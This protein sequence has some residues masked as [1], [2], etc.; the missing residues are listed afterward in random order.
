MRILQVIEFFTP[1]MG[2]SPQVVFQIATH[3]AQLGHKVTVCS[4]DY[5]I[6]EAV[7]PSLGFEQLLFPCRFAR[8][9][10]YLTPDLI[11]W[12]WQNVRHFDVIHLH[13]VRTFQNA[14]I[15]AIAQHFGIPYVLSPHGSLPLIAG[16]R[17]AKQAYDLLFGNNLL[18][19]AARLIAVSPAEAEQFKQAGLSDEKIITV[20]NGLNLSEFTQLP[21][22]GLLR[23]ELGISETVALIL[24]LGRLHP[25]KGVD[26]LIPAFAHLLTMYP[27]AYLVVAGPDDGDLVRLRQLSIRQGLAERVFFPGGFYGNDKLAALVDADLVVL[28]SQYEIFGLV[29]FEALLCGT[30]VVVSSDSAAGQ[31]IGE[32][33]AGYLTPYGDVIQLAATLVEALRDKERSARLVQSGQVFV[34]QQL[35]WPVLIHQLEAVYQEQIASANPSQRMVKS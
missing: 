17:V 32:A 19:H 14:V 35:Q 9:N 30:P 31:L 20:H 26:Q 2:G 16:R 10:F 29:P 8:W 12:A 21:D 1:K 15:G 23:S 3:L 22:R 33:E 6:A 7:F 4:S 18:T 11:K 13:S 24:F 27:D 5:G 25:I 28:P 34:R